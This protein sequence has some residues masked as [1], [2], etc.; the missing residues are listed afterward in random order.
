VVE[1]DDRLRPVACRAILTAF[2]TASAPELNRADFFSWSPGVSS[3]SFSQT[4]DVAV[5]G[6]DH[7]AGVGERGDLLGDGVDD[8]LVAIADGGHGDAGAEV[9]E[10]VAVDV[11]Q[12]ARPTPR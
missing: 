5:V 11:A 7:E 12:D 3:L 6:R 2:S 8:A 9:D 1:G 10:L 4:C